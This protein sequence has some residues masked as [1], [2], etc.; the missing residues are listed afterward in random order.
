MIAMTNDSGPILPSLVVGTGAIQVESITGHGAARAAL[1]MRLDGA[2]VA[3]ESLTRETLFSF[4]LEL[5]DLC[6]NMVDDRAYHTSDS[7]RDG[8]GAVSSRYEDGLRMH[9]RL[10]DRL[11]ILQLAQRLLERADDETAN[12]FLTLL[13]SAS[14]TGEIPIRVEVDFKH[15]PTAPRPPAALSLVT[16][17]DDVNTPA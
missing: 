9:Y 4:A 7:M 14:T 2:R 6:E 15:A 1:A 12:T 16:S 8:K 5:L 3:T 10:R 11:P 17:S 13:A